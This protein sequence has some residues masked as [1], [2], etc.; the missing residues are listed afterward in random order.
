MRCECEFARG[1]VT[2]AQRRLRSGKQGQGERCGHG[3]AQW[4]RCGI[5][6]PPPRQRLLWALTVRVVQVCLCEHRRRMHTR[7]HLHGAAKPHP[8]Q[9]PCLRIMP[10]RAVAVTV[11]THSIALSMLSPRTCTAE[12]QKLFPLFFAAAQPVVVR[13]STALASGRLRKKA[14]HR[15]T[16]QRHGHVQHRVLCTGASRRASCGGASRGAAR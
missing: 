13:G 4:R 10:R 3:R 7:C 14:Q 11:A 5:R 8:L 1:T 9:E 15:T 12:P 6:R 2:V 16:R